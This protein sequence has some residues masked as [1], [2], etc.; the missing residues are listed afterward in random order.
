MSVP[1]R[2]VGIKP[3]IGRIVHY[4]QD[5]VK[6]RHRPAIITAV[7]EGGAIEAEVFGLG[8]A[9]FVSGVMEDEETKAIATWH[10]PEREE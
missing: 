1:S 3:S 4:V 7:Q 8:S 9:R 5:G 2:F 6:V 10:W